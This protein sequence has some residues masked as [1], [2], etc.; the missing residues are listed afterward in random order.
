MDMNKNIERKT[1]EIDAT[2]ESVGR[3]AARAALILTGK[4]KATYEP[5]VDGGDI[6]QI[7]N[8]SKV[9]FTGR[10]FVQKDY[11]HHTMY[12]GGLKTTPMKKVFEKDPTDVIRR[13]VNGMLPKNNRRT[14][15]MKRLK[16]QA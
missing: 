14:T 3:I 11:R 8:A 12:P 5:R 4:H 2:G 13:A 7:L 16:I 9:K 10:K 6:V 15:L 1:K